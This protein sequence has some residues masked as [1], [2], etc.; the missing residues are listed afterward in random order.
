MVAEVWSEVLEK[1]V[2]RS[3]LDEKLRSRVRGLLDKHMGVWKGLPAK[4]HHGGAE[5]SLLELEAKLKYEDVGGGL[6][7]A[8]L[9]VRG[10]GD[11]FSSE[12]P[13]AP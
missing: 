8:Q 1:P 11:G 2:V 4:E 13:L 5:G 12:L 10:D 9:R 6:Q 3:M 7:R